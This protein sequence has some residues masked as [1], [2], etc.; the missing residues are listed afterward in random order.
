MISC[1]EIW[2]EFFERYYQK[3]LNTI[4]FSTQDGD[5]TSFY[6]KIRDLAIFKEGRLLEELYEAPD[7]VIEHANEAIKK[8]H[9][10]YGKKLDKVRVRF[11]EP[12]EYKKLLVKQVNHSYIGK[13]VSVVGIIQKIGEPRSIII[14]GVYE[15]KK[16]GH[17]VDA[18]IVE[19][20][21]EKDANVCP[22]CNNRSFRLDKKSLVR[23]GFRKIKIQDLPEHLDAN[24]IPIQLEAWLFGDLVHQVR[25]G[26]KVILNGILR[27]EEKQLDRGEAVERLYLEVNSVEFI[28]ID[29]RTIKITKEDEEEI[30][31]LA[32]NPEVY[33]LLSESIAPSIHG[34]EEIKLAALLQLFG[35]CQITTADGKIRGDIHILIVGDPSVAKSRLARAVALVAPRAVLSTGVSSTGAGLTVSVVKDEDNRWSLEAGVLV[36][37]DRGLAVLDEMEKSKREDREHMLEALEQQTITISKAGIHATLNSRCAVLATANPKYGKFDRSLPIADQ[38]HLEPN[39]LS[40]F[41]LIFVLIDDPNERK[42]QE[43]ANFILRDGASRTPPLNPDLIR[44]YILYAREKIKDVRLSEEA[45]QAITDFYVSLRGAAKQNIPITPRQLEGLRRLAQASAKIQLRNVATKEDAERAIKL[46]KISLSQWALDPETGVFDITYGLTGVGIKSRDRLSIIREII[47]SLDTGEGA[48]Y[49]E[50]IEKAVERG[51]SRSH[52]EEII[53][54]MR[55]F[56]DAYFPR[57]GL[58]KLVRR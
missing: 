36:L 22:R 1:C 16:C 33:T 24:E 35:G 53:N 58:V 55:E 15:C 41:D 54:K 48:D 45:I 4:A 23:T 19:T 30:Q 11:V 40:R 50:V 43:L 27:T 42:D 51:I 14:S 21:I 8:A 44:K 47:E 52:A 2:V 13:F 57:V 6:V 5:E 12:F 20:S 7:L 39:I 10:I 18:R 31:K 34:L 26:D 46:M 29:I 9:N 28:D 17:K 3:E 56:G 32:K 38:I 25:A 37:A 49:N